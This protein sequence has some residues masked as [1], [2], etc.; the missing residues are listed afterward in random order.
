MSARLSVTSQEIKER[1]LME[2]IAGR[3]THVKVHLIT[4]GLF[5][6]ARDTRF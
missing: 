1:I 2:S 3:S 4:K 5:Y 6:K